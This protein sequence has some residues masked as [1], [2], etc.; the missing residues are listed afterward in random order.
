VASPYL[1]DA[2]KLAALRDALPA[3][4]AGI[5]LDAGTAGP[6]P[7]ETAAAMAELA[8][9]ELRTGRAH[10]AFREETLARLDEARA[11]V[12]ALLTADVDEVALRSSTSDGLAAAIWSLPWA[13]GDRAVTTTAEHPGLLGP[14]GVAGR[15]LGVE[16]QRVDVD[17]AT[18]DA[19]VDAFERALERG[20]RL[21]ALSHVTW[22]RGIVLP[23]ARIA[24][25]A[26]ERGAFVIVDGAQAAG[27]IPL[28]V[29]SLG[30]DFYALPA[31]KWLLGPEGVGALWVDRS[32]LARTEPPAP[33]PPGVED[34]DALGRSGDAPPSAG[35]GREDAR[36][37]DAGSWYRPAVTGFARSVGW[38]TMYVGLDWSY[39][40]ASR[41][42]R[43]VADRL[44]AVHGVEV[45]TPLDRMGTLVAFRVRGWSA[46]A[47]L[48]ELGAR[49]FVLA[50]AFPEDD[51]IR[52]SVGAW[53][54]EDELERF[55]AATELVARHTPSTMPARP[56]LQILGGQP[57]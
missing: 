27:A 53:A 51:L 23:V 57:R 17:A 19:I 45:L 13:R 40:R 24:A 2:A 6:L 31:H 11:A 35:A 50:R 34:A 30:V 7:S 26:R 55:L 4:G 33:R 44:S 48:E 37:F 54:R 5:H 46:A 38:L 9:W 20:A 22:R 32:A 25:L 42:A 56:T 43:S 39:G 15:R 47:A 18:D 16:V 12:A 14:L 21:V 36:R 8:G 49:A 41:L 52:V 1:P 3:V 29:P 10:A 28:D